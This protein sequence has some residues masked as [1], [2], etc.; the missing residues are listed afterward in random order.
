MLRSVRNVAMD[1]LSRRDHSHKEL[2]A[3]LSLRGF[4]SNEISVALDKLQLENLLND[5][6]FS[7]S[8]IRYRVKKGFGPL[9]IQN[10]LVEKGIEYEL[11]QAYLGEYESQWF[12]LMQQQ[13]QKKFG[14]CI[15]DDYKEKMKQARFLQNK[16]FSPESVMRL[17]RR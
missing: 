7:E 4:E 3:K 15:P 12:G 16:G 14:A 17:F 8:Y 5:E 9:R 10:E 6:R 13:R 11:I 2:F 1:L